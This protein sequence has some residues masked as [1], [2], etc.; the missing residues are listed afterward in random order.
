MTLIAVFALMALL[1]VFGLA[2]PLIKPPARAVRESTTAVLKRQ[3]GDIESQSTDGEISTEEAKS[4]AT[5]VKRRLLTESKAT[6]AVLIALPPRTRVTVAA[7]M[8]G[9]ILAAAAILYGDI[10][11]PDL[12]SLPR[13]QVAAPDMNGS[14]PA[15]ADIIARVKAR[16]KTSP[17]D[18]EGW[19]VL[20][21]AY[22]V[23]G[24]PSD[25][26][27]SYA[28][29]IALD[30]ANAADRSAE[31][32]ALVQAAGGQVT[33]GALTAFEASLALDPGDPRARYFLA[34]AKEQRGD[35]AGAMADWIALL[36]S[37][38]SSAPWLAQVKGFVE[39]VAR[40]HGEDISGRLSSVPEPANA[41]VD[42]AGPLSQAEQHA[43]IER[44]VEGLAARLKAQPN[45]VDG[46]TRLM[47][48]RM[49][50]GETKAAVEAYADARRA[51]SNAPEV[52]AQLRNTARTLKVPGA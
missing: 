27:N 1:A 20:G 10:G 12:G 39:Q 4:L 24:R 9:F 52:Q 19:R 28:R 13:E 21:W 45:D 41:Q 14:V 46:W 26:A 42:Q 3:L 33:P 37:A 38:P 7:M 30:P 2:L 32:D 18:K 35:H 6:E 8:G 49:V 40:A 36:K 31:G 34:L 15:L 25:A 17:G 51:F 43:M 16:L 11:R 44:M 22:L 48:A 29:A 5:E 47:R 23:S 50:L